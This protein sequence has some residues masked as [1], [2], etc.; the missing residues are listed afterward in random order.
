M[1]R[2]LKKLRI[3]EVSCVIKGSNSDARVVI[4]KADDGLTGV[5]AAFKAATAQS[6]HDK[7]RRNAQRLADELAAKDKEPQMTRTEEMQEMHKFVKAGGMSAVAKHILTTG[8]TSLNE[9][10]YTELVQVDATLRKISFEAAFAEPTTQKAY[11]V[12]RDA[13]QVKTYLK[14]YPGM[15]SV[16]VVST[17]TGSTLTT[18][19]SYKAAAQLARLVEDQRARAPT[20]T[21]SA[22]F[23]A[24][25]SNPENKELVQRAHRRPDASSTS[26]DELQQR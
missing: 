4:R 25:Y 6:F 24:V 11:S 21:T 16:E 23:E 5:A 8:G 2:I 18:D 15:M 26:G 20:L 13:T 9:H 14:S 3:D 7:K 1:T 17:E 19:D 22:L 12:V 10:E